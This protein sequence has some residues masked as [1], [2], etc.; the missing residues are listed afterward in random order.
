MRNAPGAA[1][2]PSQKEMNDANAR[3][4]SRDHGANVSGA[5]GNMAVA[6]DPS[7]RFIGSGPFTQYSSDVTRPSPAAL[8]EL[9][10]QV[11][12]A[13]TQGQRDSIEDAWK[14]Y[15]R[16]SR[17]DG[18]Q[19]RPKQPAVSP[20]QAPKKD[21]T[22][23]AGW[24]GIYSANKGVIGSNPDLIQPGMRLDLGGGQSHVVEKGESLSSIASGAANSSAPVPP[25][26][27]AGLGEGYGQG[28]E[29]GAAASR[30]VEQMLKSPTESTNTGATNAPMPPERPSGTGGQA[31][32]NAGGGSAPTGWGTLKPP[33]SSGELLGGG[34]EASGGSY[35]SGG[36]LK[37]SEGPGSAGIHSLAEAGGSGGQTPDQTEKYGG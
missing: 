26:R 30:N 11:A 32:E 37:V 22:D 12:R 2:P 35:S 10:A 17:D 4:W 5:P 34:G 36:D 20:S 9:N 14:S 19:W 23:D 31:E 6:S 8:S 3:F 18:S 15:M 33:A 1:G 29:P 27:P 28:Q 16:G 25:V 13:K 24:E 7:E 21:N